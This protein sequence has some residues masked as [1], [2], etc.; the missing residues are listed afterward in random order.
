[1]APGISPICP[2]E[3]ALLD[4]SGFTK[5]KYHSD[6]RIE[7]F[8]ARFVILGNHQIEGLDYTETF[9]PTVKM[10]TIHTVLAVAAVKNWELHEMDMHN[11]FLHGDLEEEVYM[12]LPPGFLVSH[13]GM[14]CKLRKSLYGMRQ[15]PR[16]WFAKLSSALFDMAS[17]KIS[18]II[19][20]SIFNMMECNL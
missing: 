17:H 10:V 8:K 7:R 19:H 4:V 11:V 3:N 13:R 6:G 16:C 1:M 12:K 15:A 5:I 18:L 20:Y 9:A 2:L 14:V